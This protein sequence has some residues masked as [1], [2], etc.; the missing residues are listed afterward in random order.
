MAHTSTAVLESSQL[1]ETH[2][3]FEDPIQGLM[4]RRHCTHATCGTY[5]DDVKDKPAQDFL[6][7]DCLENT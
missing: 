4:Y 6:C 7:D 5:I 2:P 1:D 3:T